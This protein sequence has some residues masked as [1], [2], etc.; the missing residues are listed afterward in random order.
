[1]LGFLFT[2][3]QIILGAFVGLICLIALYV[4]IFDW[5]KYN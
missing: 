3:I 1:M 2:A 4:L 5:D